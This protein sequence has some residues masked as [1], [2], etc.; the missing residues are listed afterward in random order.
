MSRELVEMWQQR[1]KNRYL[2]TYLETITPYYNWRFPH[3]TYMI[4]RLERGLERAVAGETVRMMVFEPPRHGKSSLITERFPAYCLHKRPYWKVMV[5]AFN[6]TKAIDFTRKIRNNARMSGVRISD[7][8][9][10]AMEW[11]TVHGGGA[12]AA[13]VQTGAPGYGANVLVLDDPVR[14]RADANSKVISNKIYDEFSDSFMSRLHK[15]N[16][17]IIVLTRWSELDLAGRILA[18]DPDGWEVINL[19]ALAREDDLLGRKYDEPLCPDLI[20]LKHLLYFRDKRPRTFE[21]LY[22]GNPSLATG[23]IFLRE[24]FQ[25]FLNQPSDVSRKVLSIDT[26][27]KEKESNDPSALGVWYD[28][29]TAGY[30]NDV[31]V[32]RLSYPK[33]KRLVLDVAAR[34]DPDLILIEDK[35]SGQSLIQD[36]QNETRLP[37]VPVQVDTDKVS[38]AHA[39]TGH[40]ESG[41][42]Y[43]RKGA[44][45]LPDYESELLSFPNGAN[46][47]QVD[48][49]TQYINNVMVEVPDVIIV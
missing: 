26:A 25:Y 43:H 17:V 42:I 6:E 37:I 24:Y 27:F 18:D 28:S 15:I 39:S 11:E 23:N 20:P 7:E 45:W 4:D 5:G 34:E 2:R 10:A 41:N 49:T 44:L 9:S 3:I 1:R 47:D 19:P 40:Y 38:R 13:G 14:N 29:P 35:A 22:Q 32:E 21:S 8:R 30:L 46:D 31:I 48:M 36:L 33:L 12:K 16:M